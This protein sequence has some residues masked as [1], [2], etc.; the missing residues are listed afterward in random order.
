MAV[1]TALFL[2]MMSK[3]YAGADAV[4]QAFFEVT[5]QRRNISVAE[6][7]QRCGWVRHAFADQVR[8]GF[9]CQP[10]RWRVEFKLDFLSIWSSGSEVAL[11]QRCF[12]TYGIDPRTAPLPEVK[13]LCRRLGV[14]NPFIRR[15]EEYV[16]NLLAWL[17][18]N[19]SQKTQTKPR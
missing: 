17:A 10:L 9:P 8:A 4:A 3:L 6:L 19:P 11:R 14:Q 18:V 16:L 1:E 12:E 2:N 13:D 5:L 15:Q 7:A